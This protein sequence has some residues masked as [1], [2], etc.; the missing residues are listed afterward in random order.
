M[1]AMLRRLAME[2]PFRIVARALLPHLRP[3][4]DTRSL[5]EL[6]PRP[7]YLLGILQAA[8]QARAQNLSRIAVMEFG[9]ASGRGL[10]VMQDEAEA[11]ERATGV[12]IDVYGFD[13]GAAGLPEFIGDYRD[14][15][16]AWRAG[17]FAMD[18]EKLRLLLKPRTSLIL[19]N[20]S[21]TV[22]AFFK[23]DTRAHIGFVAIDV[24]LYLLA[25]DALGIF[26]AEGSRMLWNTPLYFD[27]IE[28]A[29]NHRWA[30]EL[31]A[32]NEFNER[33]EG[34]KID[35]WYGI[36]ADRPFPERGMYEDVCCARSCGHLEGAA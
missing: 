30:G 33:N 3:D 12:T 28:F 10:L 6:S 19:G 17:D 13:M 21:E 2:P 26:T 24:D 25:R 20:V 11:V 22:P 36:R 18:E 9:V 14:H 27:D 35:R 31:L 34:I 4:I 1:K 32:I 15:P 16:D 23:T 29:F 7:H 5:W 8:R